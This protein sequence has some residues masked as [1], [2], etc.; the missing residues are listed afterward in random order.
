MAT[1]K[2]EQGKAAKKGTI[3]GLKKRKKAVTKQVTIQLDGEISDRINNLRSLYTA[4]RDKDRLSNEADKAPGIQ[5]EIDELIAGSSDTEVKFLFKS[6]GR[7]RYDEIV[8]EHPPSKEAVKEGAEFDADTF[9]PALVSEACFKIVE[10]DGS[11]IDG[12]SLKDAN[13]IFL[14]PDWNGA[15]LR[16]IFF[17]ALEVNTETGDIPLS[18]SGSEGTLNSLLSLA[19]QQREVSPTPSTLGE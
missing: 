3:A 9:P 12:I 2:V 7:H 15:E 17:G 18:K 5:A 6:V 16:R 19:M 8:D 11:E 14:S 13:E 4:A 10:A 1:S